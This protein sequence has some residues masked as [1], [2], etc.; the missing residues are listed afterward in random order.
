MSVEEPGELPHVRSSEEVA[1]L[2][3]DAASEEEGSFETETV[4]AVKS[5]F[6]EKEE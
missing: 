4:A 5:Q 3:A 6:I 2:I 1:E